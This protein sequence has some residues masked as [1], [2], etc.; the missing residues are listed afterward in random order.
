MIEQ[1]MT[2]KQLKFL[3]AGMLRDGKKGGRYVLDVC[4]SAYKMPATGETCLVSCDNIRVHLTPLVHPE[5]EPGKTYELITT[6]KEKGSGVVYLKDSD[7]EYPDY[8]MVLAGLDLLPE[9]KRI[10]KIHTPD[11]DFS[12]AFCAVKL[13]NWTGRVVRMKYILDLVPGE[14]EIYGVPGAHDKPLFFGGKDAY[15]MVMPI[16]TA[17]CRDFR[18]ENLDQPGA[19]VSGDETV[20]N[21]GR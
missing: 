12:R 6:K 9:D 5:V 14:Y 18:P 17:A 4:L 8:P 19:Y 15:A 1:R 7:L 10:V 21:K 2:E 20:L 3:A 11:K 16:G 13:Y